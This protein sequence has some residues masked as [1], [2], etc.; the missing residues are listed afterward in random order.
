LQPAGVERLWHPVVAS[1]RCREHLEGDGW[2]IVPQGHCEVGD[3]GKKSAWAGVMTLW[4]GFAKTAGRIQTTLGPLLMSNNLDAFTSQFDKYPLQ[5][6]AYLE[7]IAM[8]LLA[9]SVS[10]R[11]GPIPK[12]YTQKFSP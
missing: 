10:P 9:P 1:R 2:E 11:L 6:V 5:S 8:V 3:G 7:A 4:R 12:W